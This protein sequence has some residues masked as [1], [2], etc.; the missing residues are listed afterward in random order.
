MIRRAEGQSTTVFSAMSGKAIL[1]CIASC[2]GLAASA[3][4]ASSADYLTCS[5]SNKSASLSQQFEQDLCAAAADA[6][7]AQLLAGE[8]FIRAIEM[9]SDDE[10][11]VLFHSVEATIPS[12]REISFEYA[13]G[14]AAEWRRDMEKRSS[15]LHVEIVDAEL[16]S[17]SIELFADT[18]RYLSR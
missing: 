14:T 16:N 15:D 1:V 2:S 13:L 10:Q 8:D 4:S 5:V 18:L 6:T 12:A 17:A 7:S 11:S 3:T 9:T